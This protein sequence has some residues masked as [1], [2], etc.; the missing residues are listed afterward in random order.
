MR[1][2]PKS[3]SKNQKKKKKEKGGEDGKG[4]LEG[5]WEKA[6]QNLGLCF[7]NVDETGTFSLP[8][9]LPP[10]FGGVNQQAALWMC[11]RFCAQYARRA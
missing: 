11:G 9:S 10:L 6:P 3:W 8:S 2:E 1:K 5:W 7:G 4:E